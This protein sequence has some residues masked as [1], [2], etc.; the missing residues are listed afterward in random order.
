[1]AY[2]QENLYRSVTE[3]FESLLLLYDE[4]LAAFIS[5]ATSLVIVIS[6]LTAA[7]VVFFGS[8]LLSGVLSHVQTLQYK[9]VICSMG[10][11]VPRKTS[12]RLY[13][14]FQVHWV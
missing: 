7:I 3:V 6:G 11:A 12:K 1:V 10:F 9:L 5:L 14:H 2:V 4:Q 13:K 8:F